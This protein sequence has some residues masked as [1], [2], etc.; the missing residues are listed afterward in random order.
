MTIDELMPD[1]LVADRRYHVN[2]KTLARWDARPEL[3][4]PKPVVINGRRY[5]R[6]RELDEFDRLCVHARTTSV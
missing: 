4:F 1:R 5:R 3:G 6:I 2:L